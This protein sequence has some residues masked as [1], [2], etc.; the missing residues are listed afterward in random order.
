M[1]ILV[2]GNIAIVALIER[3]RILTRVAYEIVVNV[4]WLRTF[5]RARINYANLNTREILMVFSKH[6]LTAIYVNPFF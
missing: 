5:Q 6:F 2:I 1:Y 3:V 4:S